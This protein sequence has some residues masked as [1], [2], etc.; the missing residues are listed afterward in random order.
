MVCDT[1]DTG[2]I[3]AFSPPLV[4]D[5]AQTTGLLA[6]V[7]DATLKETE[8]G[9]KEKRARSACPFGGSVRQAETRR[10]TGAAVRRRKGQ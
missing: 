6:I 1:D 10:R 5:D 2:D 7:A 8:K 4:I 3:P 9:G